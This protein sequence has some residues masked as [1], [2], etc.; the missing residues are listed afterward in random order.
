[1]PVILVHIDRH[2]LILNHFNGQ[3]DGEAISRSQQERVS[4]G[5]NRLIFRLV[6]CHLGVEDRHTGINGL[7]KVLFLDLDD[8]DDVVRT[9]TQ[10]AVMALVFLDHRVNH[11]IQEGMINTQQLAVTGSPAQ[12]AAQ[13]IATAF[14]G[15]QNAVSDHKGRCPDMVCDHTQR[16]IGLGA[17]AVG[18][19][20][21]RG[22]MVS[23]VHDRIH[24]KQ[25][26]HI[27][28]DHRQPLQAHTGVDILLD[29][30]CIVAVAV[31]IEL[32][33]HIVPDFHVPI[34]VTAHST[35][36]L[37]AAVLLAPVI[38]NFRARTAGTGAVLPE[39]IRLTEAEDILGRNTDLLIPD[40]KGFLVIFVDRRIQAVL[41][42]TY[43]LGQKLPAP[44]NC[45]MLKVITEGEVAQHFKIGAM[46]GSFADIF[47][48]AGTDTLLTGTDPMPGRLYFAL[49][50]GLHRSHTGIDQQK[51]LIILGDQRKAGQAQML[52]ALKKRQEHFTQL[53]YA[54]CFFSHWI[55]LHNN[56]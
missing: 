56:I 30:L 26:V 32:G 16:H 45:L 10:I 2:S 37:A 24:V 34:A 12:K 14:V 27:L 51:R 47:N 13:D 46:A 36:R 42:Q 28:T 49:K 35:I 53:I 39:I 44:G 41:L 33:E 3:V 22:H 31:I 8:T 7:G 54:V 21:D 43:H 50:I 52:L 40:L 48:I 5:E 25:A 29:Q 15:R 20:G 17:L 23:N 1:M 9:L 55:Y 6:L 11:L 4:A 18:S 19:A 38:V